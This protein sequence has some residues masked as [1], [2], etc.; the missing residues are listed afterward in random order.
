MS[1]DHLDVCIS[2]VD[3]DRVIRVVATKK[4]KNTPTGFKSLIAFVQKKCNMDLPLCFV[5]EA[6]GTYH[7]NVAYYLH[8]L[9]Y[10]VCIELPNKT[11]KFAKSLNSKSKTDKADAQILAHYALE[12]N[13]KAWVPGNRN[14]LVM[15]QLSR[16]KGSIQEMIT[17]LK[18]QIHAIRN[19]HEPNMEII[20][21]KQETIKTLSKQIK[22]VEASINK[23]IA[24]DTEIKKDVERLCTIRGVGK[25]TAVEVP[26]NSQEQYDSGN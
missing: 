20:K 21:R 22:A 24:S 25:I 26:K 14:V 7:E 5:L 9:G 8:E 6:T 23:V 13:P 16:E 17:M 1:K 19:S 4:F 2:W 11:E 15:R 12:R 18:N 3:G 10:K